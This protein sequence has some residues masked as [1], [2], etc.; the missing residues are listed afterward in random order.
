M[1]DSQ[2]LHEPLLLATVYG[3]H[4]DEH[5]KS[6][7]PPVTTKQ[8]QRMLKLMTT[9]SQQQM[10]APTRKQLLGLSVIYVM[11]G[12]MLGGLFSYMGCSILLWH[13]SA[14]TS[15][16]VD[17]SRFFQSGSVALYSLCWSGVTCL[18]TLCLYTILTASISSNWC[19][20]FWGSRDSSSLPTAIVP[21]LLQAR[22]ARSLLF[23][24]YCVAVG[25]FLGFCVACIDTEVRS[26]TVPWSITVLTL[27]V[28]LV[29]VLLMISCCCLATTAPLAD[30][31]DHDAGGDEIVLFSQDEETADRILLTVV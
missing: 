4:D 14:K 27:V 18:V 16:P 11:A 31:L 24:E 5:D 10:V 25:V 15:N 23:L 28:A 2:Q 6:Q 22:K 1:V 9:A 20:P 13:D 29:W 26:L 30:F 8:Q 19:F 12:M 21:G 17:A 3:D 7:R